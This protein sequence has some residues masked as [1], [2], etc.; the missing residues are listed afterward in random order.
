MSGGY[1]NFLDKVRK[2]ADK[3]KI[4]LIFDECTSGFRETFGGLHL[5][6]NIK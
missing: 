5:K 2:L 3:K 4:I 1:G 6:Y